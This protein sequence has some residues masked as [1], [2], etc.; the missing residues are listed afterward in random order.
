M[1]GCHERLHDHALIR[2]L[3]DDPARGPGGRVVTTPLLALAMSSGK[4]L[5]D[6]REHRTSEK[7]WG[8]AFSTLR[9]KVAETPSRRSS[10]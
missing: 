9:S 10:R 1:A 6:R 3:L 5:K 7:P 8:M 2:G 4:L